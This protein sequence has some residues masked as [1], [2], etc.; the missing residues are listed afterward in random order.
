MRSLLLLAL[1]LLSLGCA[2]APSGPPPLASVPYR[3]DG[4]LILVE[5]SVNGAPPAWLM[6]DSGASHSVL[7][8]AFAERLGLALTGRGS[9]TGTGRGAIE[10]GH[11]GPVAL[12]IGGFEAR[13]P[14]PWVI[15]L[16]G[17]PIAPD[18]AG[19]VG[20]EIFRSHVVRIDP[21][22]RRFEIFEPDGFSHD[23][24]GATVPLIVE[25]DKLFLDVTLTV[26]PGLTVERRV[27]VDTGSE[28]SVSDPIVARSETVR[29]TVLGQGL[30]EDYEA[31]SGVFPNVT[32]GPYSFADVW[33]PGSAPPAI[34]M[35]LLRRFVLTFDAPRGLL[36]LRPTPALAEPVPA[37]G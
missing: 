3:S 9:T 14:D 4:K 37:P 1:S 25:G 31:V 7:G 36:H 2:A 5:A 18:T 17:V 12:R 34:G 11:V 28:S 10:I 27:R 24:G 22:R 19:L 16:S 8:T 33:G 20:S 6:V 21:V 13:L 26:R 32:L 30:G 35:E 29:R 23:P 15:D